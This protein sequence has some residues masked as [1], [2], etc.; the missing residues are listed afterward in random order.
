MSG[1]RGRR[2]K[3]LKDD[4]KD[5]L[6]YWKLKENEPDRALWKTRFGKRYGLVVRQ[7]TYRTILSR[8]NPNF[9]TEKKKGQ[10]A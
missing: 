8:I 5:K 10:A 6:G 2:R 4:S 9:G 7:T 1:T 3:Q